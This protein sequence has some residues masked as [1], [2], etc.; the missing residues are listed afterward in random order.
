MAVLPSPPT[1]SLHEL[2]SRNPSTPNTTQDVL[3]V[4]CA[5]P[6]SGQY[7]PGT[8]ALY[9]ALVATCVFAR[10]SPWLKNAC[11]AAALLFPAVAAI[12]GIVLAA[13]HVDGAVDMDIYGALQLCSVGILA[14]PVTARL[15]R[16][17]FNEPGRNIIFLWTVLLLAG[18]LSLTVEFFRTQSIDCVHDDS[19]NPV[20]P[21]VR[22]FPYG[23]T[24][25]LT[26]S[27]EQGPFSPM[28]QG[29]ANNIYVIPAPNRFTFSTATLVA[30]ACCIPPIL[31][32]IFMWI[33]ILDVNWKKR[34]PG[35]EDDQDEI[36]GTN[37]AT[38]GGMKKVNKFIRDLLSVVE[39]PVFGGA[40]LAI[41]VIGEMN[42]FSAPV[43]YQTERM[44]SVG[45]WAPIAGTGLALLGS[46][47]LVV[48]PYS[49][50][51]TRSQPGGESTGS[52]AAQGA[53]DMQRRPS[54]DEA[55]TSSTIAPTI[56][57]HSTYQSKRD[58]GRLK[59]TKVLMAI[60]NSLVDAVHDQLNDAGIQ[61]GKA[62]RFPTIP[63]EKQ[64][65]PMLNRIKKQYN[66]GGDAYISMPP[67]PRPSR[68]DSLMSGAVSDVDIERNSTKSRTASPSPSGHSCQRRHANT[69]PSVKTS[70]EGQDPTSA[71]QR[72]QRDTLEVPALVHHS[73]VRSRRSS[74]ITS[75]ASIST[76]LRPP[77]IV[78]SSDP[79]PSSSSE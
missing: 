52:V 51:G 8:R 45:Q 61:H 76:G 58:A 2:T 73:P 14:G 53:K 72:P 37:G 68:A 38:V 64:R 36:E 63:G 27:E 55:E 19:G 41:L 47:F 69:L 29:S 7:G 57:R 65:N 35:G 43:D 9:Y 60:N 31:S 49:D 66:Y 62:S 10:N 56:S 15:S 40:V 44:A 54:N 6:V 75:T 26:C 67:T 33:Q 21:N 13:L 77:A 34:F 18:L 20:S 70:F 59:V 78:V 22:D 74:S 23:T 16:T 50:E 48:A 39:I 12:H 25:G 32:L 17:Y 3:Q 24:C 4:I 1:V 5:W 79:E 30:A 28:R 11:L 42:F 71:N 46:L